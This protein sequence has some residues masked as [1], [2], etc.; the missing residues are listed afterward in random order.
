MIRGEKNG[1]LNAAAVRGR[2]KAPL[3]AASTGQNY[4]GGP[5]KF[6][7]NFSEG[8]RLAYYLFIFYIP[9]SAAGRIFL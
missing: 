6:G 8:H 4:A 7:F 3:E 1:V 9:F 2:A 5:G